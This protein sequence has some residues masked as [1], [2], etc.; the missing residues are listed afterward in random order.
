M[1]CKSEPTTK[2]RTRS[3]RHLL[4][5]TPKSRASSK[6]VPAIKAPTKTEPAA[7]TKPKSKGS[8]R[9]SPSKRNRN[10][11]KQRN[12][13]SVDEWSETEASCNGDDDEYVPPKRRIRRHRSS[14]STSSSRRRSSRGGGASSGSSS[15]ESEASN[16]LEADT[17]SGYRMLNWRKNQVATPGFVKITKPEGAAAD[18]D[19]LQRSSSKM[20]DTSNAAYF[21]RHYRAEAREKLFYEELFESRMKTQRILEEREERSEQRR[22]KKRAPRGDPAKRDEPDSAAAESEAKGDSVHSADAIDLALPKPPKGPWS[23]KLGSEYETRPEVPSNVVNEPVFNYN[24]DSLRKRLRA[25]DPL[26]DIGRWWKRPSH[27]IRRTDYGMM[28]KLTIATASGHDAHSAATDCAPNGSGGGTA[29]SAS[30][31]SAGA[32]SEEMRKQE[33]I[34]LY[35]KMKEKQRE[36]VRERKQHH[37]HH[38]RKKK[39]KRRH[40]EEGSR[41]VAGPVDVRTMLHRE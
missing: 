35:L 28:G 29:S 19:Q 12:R 25:E 33:L 2:S 8:K 38:R 13:K 37:H 16:A 11:R 6:S 39:R 36:G 10:S 22:K 24:M 26:R 21:Y 31:Q 41:A 20:E 15:A 34:K 32:E 23:Y 4:P 27:L 7:K 17:P 3:L 9:K 1:K 14:E 30:T 40:R 5:P 18:A